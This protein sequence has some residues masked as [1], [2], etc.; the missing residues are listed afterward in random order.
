MFR[1]AMQSLRLLLA[2]TLL[3]GLLYPLTVTGLARVF[4]PYRAAGSLVIQDGQVVG[5]TLIGQDFTSPRYFHG[6]PS[7]AGK[8]Y[9][10]ASSGG[11]NF[12][13]TSAALI[14]SVKANLARVEKE[15]PG[16]TPGMIPVDLVTASAS[17]LD[18]DISPAAALLQVPRVARARGIP[19]SEVKKLVFTHIKGRQFGLLGEP[20]VNVLELNMALDRLAS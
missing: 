10:A 11:S 4:F 7:A 5:S 20:R 18:P 13:P 15:D 16:V 19:E 9:D 3:A 17:G 14:D 12:G 6:R 2:L 1:T 8:G